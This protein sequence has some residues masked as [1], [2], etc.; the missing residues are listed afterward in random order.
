MAPQ[1]SG[2]RIHLWD[3]RPGFESRQGI[4]FLGKT[5]QC[6]CVQL[7]CNLQ[8]RRKNYQDKGLKNRN[9]NMHPR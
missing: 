9:N 8:K 3:R 7:T 2:H 4:R 1:H 5:Y 6:C